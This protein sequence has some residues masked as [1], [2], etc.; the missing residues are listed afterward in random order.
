MIAKCL[1]VYTWISFQHAVE[2]STFHAAIGRPAQNA[3]QSS[4]FKNVIYGT[5]V[6]GEV[7]NCLV[8]RLLLSNLKLRKQFF[9]NI[10]RR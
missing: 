8:F 1:S 10:I 5:F 7:C 3:F 9:C 6:Y 4:N 2:M